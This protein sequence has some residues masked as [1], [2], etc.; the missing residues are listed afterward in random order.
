VAAVITTS[1][2]TA[3]TLG[4]HYGVASERIIVAPP[5][6]ERR[7]LARGSGGPVLNLLALG[8]VVPRKNHAL[9]IAAL[10]GLRQLP[11][12]LSLVG[13]LARAPDHV[14]ALRGMIAGCGLSGR[15]RL[16]GELADDRLARL[17]LGTDLYVSASRHEGYG[18][19]IQEAFAHGVPVVATQAGAVGAWV[20][21]R[22][23]RLVRDC[24]LPALRT[25]LAAVLASTPALASLR[26]GAI[27][28][29]RALS[30]WETTARQV[31]DGLQRLIERRS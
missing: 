16:T 7:P 26:R 31:E 24:R 3:R 8:A 18:M 20:G 1:P 14:A 11:W 12:R 28:R 2:S 4:L 30:D 17:W 23:A 21:R 22:G 9:L 27:A 19:A 6:V 25:A 5:G 15:V 13:N 10:A 29:R